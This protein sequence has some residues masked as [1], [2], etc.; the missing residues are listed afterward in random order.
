MHNTSKPLPSL[1][2]HT[3][4]DEIL[5]NG[6][7][8]TGWERGGGRFV[9]LPVNDWVVVEVTSWQNLDLGKGHLESDQHQSMSNNITQIDPYLC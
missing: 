7:V 5:M 1:E 3:Y 6:R 8:G 4:L 9:A 2:S